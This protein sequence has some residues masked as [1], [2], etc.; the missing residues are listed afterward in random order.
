MCPDDLAPDDPRSEQPDDEIRVLLATLDHPVPALSVASIAATARARGPSRPARPFL[1]WAAAIAL[2]VGA[3]GVALAA[4]GSPLL[5]WV[6]TVAGRLGL[7]PGVSQA[8]VSPPPTRASAGIALPPSDRLAIVISSAGPGAAAR[9]SLA[10]GSEVVVRAP[11]SAASFT[12]G[13]DRLLVDLG[14][15][16]DTLT[17]EIPRTAPRVELFVGDARVLVAER[18]KIATAITP[19]PAGGYTVLLSPTG[20]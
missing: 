6:E 16:G 8:P 11:A 7:A 18:G 1:R 4:P 12:T 17:I 9:V 10:D 2:T 5:H 19:D 15:T 3:A 20:P 14:A 13:A